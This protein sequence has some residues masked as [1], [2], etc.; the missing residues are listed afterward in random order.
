MH[1]VVVGCHTGGD[2]DCRVATLRS[3]AVQWCVCISLTASLHV[4][5]EHA[6]LRVRGPCGDHQ[7]ARKPAFPW[8]HTNDISRETCP[9]QGPASHHIY[10]LS[11]ASSFSVP[12]KIDGE[13][14][15]IASRFVQVMSIAGRT[16]LWRK[17]FPEYSAR[18]PQPCLVVF[19]DRT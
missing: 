17:T 1:S 2:S 6:E 15:I 8:L 7:V 14:K 10:T 4:R 13:S 16:E 12:R 11:S 3:A 19:C 9:H 18:R 5:Y